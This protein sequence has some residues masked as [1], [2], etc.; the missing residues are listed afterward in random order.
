[1]SAD[2]LG[3]RAEIF[4]SPAHEHVE[5]ARRMQAGG[6]RREGGGELAVPRAVQGRRDLGRAAWRSGARGG[7]RRWHLGGGVRFL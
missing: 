6:G 3:L 2:W 7:S 5:V 4:S 1:M